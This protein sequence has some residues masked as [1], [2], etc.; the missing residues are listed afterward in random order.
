MSAPT[1]ADPS[2]N[3]AA[4][5]LPIEQM[6]CDLLAIIHRDG[7]HRQDEIGIEQAWMEAMMTVPFLLEAK[8]R[9]AT[10]APS[11]A[12]AGLADELAGLADDLSR[13]SAVATPG[14]WGRG[15]GEVL[16]TGATDANHT[17]VFVTATERGPL[18]Y[19]QKD[20]LTKAEANAALIVALR[21]NL[22]AILTALRQPDCPSCHGLNTS[23]PDGCGRDPETG[24]LNG[25]RLRQPDAVDT[26]RGLVDARRLAT[27]LWE[28]HWREQSPEWQPLDTIEG[29][30]SQID[31]MTVGMVR[32]EQSSALVKELRQ[33]QREWFADGGESG[34]PTIR[35]ELIG[36]LL[37][38]LRASSPTGAE[39]MREAC[40][41][42]AEKV[43][44]Q[45]MINQ[46]EREM[47]ERIVTAIRALKPSE[48]R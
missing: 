12:L 20:G 27:I 35:G 34:P 28:K 37:T 7:G 8:D 40:V 38:A 23:C 32:A 9:L 5:A 21:N 13:L 24:E 18:F 39:A 14:P 42:A 25:T 1:P 6:L 16:M 31:N 33:M 48:V 47:R 2:A 10:P 29:V 3:A 19:P 17:T 44:C 45:Y 22:P 30:L 41:A 36:Q 15:F 4:V 43:R 26:M 11:P 46:G